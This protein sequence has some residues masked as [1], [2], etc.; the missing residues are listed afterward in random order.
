MWQTL[1]STT[2]RSLTLKDDIDNLS[3][4]IYCKIPIHTHTYTILSF[5]F[6]IFLFH[7]RIV[8]AALQSP[9]ICI[10]NW[11][12]LRGT[13]RLDRCGLPKNEFRSVY[14]WVNSKSFEYLRSL[15]LGPYKSHFFKLQQL[16]SISFLK[17]TIMWLSNWS[18]FP[19]ISPLILRRVSVLNVFI[20]S[21]LNA[22]RNKSLHQN[23]YSK[24]TLLNTTRRELWYKKKKL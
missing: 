16:F 21:T 11:C 2:T 17:T 13:Y 7:F 14:Q 12:E 1:M 22:I 5:D 24:I 4:L 23:R 20:A 8:C 18:D 15:S 3:N 19:A 9:N 6:Y 10:R